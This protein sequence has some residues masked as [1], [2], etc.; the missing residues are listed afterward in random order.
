MAIQNCAFV[1]VC[2]YVH[3]TNHMCVYLVQHFPDSDKMRSHTENHVTVS[4]VSDDLRQE[5]EGVSGGHNLSPLPLPPAHQ[6]A[7]TVSLLSKHT[8]YR[9]T[10]PAAEFGGMSGEQSPSSHEPHLPNL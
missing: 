3:C 7:G 5:M 10:V 4:C 9:N 6:C 1:G 2:D 8:L